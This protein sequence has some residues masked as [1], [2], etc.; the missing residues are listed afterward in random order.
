MRHDQ[1]KLCVWQPWVNRL[2][3]ITDFWWLRP[4]AA[5]FSSTEAGWLKQHSSTDTHFWF[6]FYLGFLHNQI[7]ATHSHT[8]SVHSHGQ[9]E[10]SRASPFSLICA[11]HYT[12][13]SIRGYFTKSFLSLLFF[14]EMGIITMGGKSSTL[15]ELVQSGIHSLT[16]CK[17]IWTCSQV[18]CLKKSTLSAWQHILKT[19]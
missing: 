5:A 16:N 15:S 14:Y 10:M 17:L 9:W 2:I 18:N 4:H 19:D 13:G 12:C 7:Q 8:E 1:H 6:C 3:M 11:F